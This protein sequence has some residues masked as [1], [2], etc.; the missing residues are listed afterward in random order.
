MT[1]PLP[2]TYIRDDGKQVIIWTY[3][4]NSW[5]VPSG[6]TSVEYLIVA[7][8]GGGG[9]ALGTFG[10][11]IIQG[12]CGAGGAGGTAGAGG[13]TGWIYGHNGN[14][15][16]FGSLI[17]TGGGGG[18]FYA[19]Y[20]NSGIGT[21]YITSHDGVNGGSGGGAGAANSTPG[22]GISSQGY[23]GGAGT[24]K[25][26]VGQCA[27]GGGGAGGSG[28]A[29]SITGEGYCTCITGAGG[30]AIASDITGTTEYYGGG[31]SGGTTVWSASHYAL[32]GT[33]GINGGAGGSVGIY[34]AVNGNAGSHGFGGGGGGGTSIVST[35]NGANGGNGG[36]GCVIIAYTPPPMAPV[37]SFS[38]T[39]ISGHPP[40]TV[41]FTDTS[42][43]TPTSWLWNF[44]DETTSTLQN[45]THIYDEIGIYTI[46]LTAT[47]AIGL[48]STSYD[49]NVH[50]PAPPVA[51][52]TTNITTGGTPLT[53]IFTDTSINTPTSWL[54]NFGDGVTSTSQ[55]PRHT[56]QIS[57][58]LPVQY[59]ATLTVTNIDGSS[60]KSSTITVTV[61][62]LPIANFTTNVTSGSAPLTVNF[63]DTSTKS[64]TSWTWYFGDGFMSTDQNPTHVYTV[65]KSYIVT[66]TAL[67]SAG[68]SNKASTITV[69]PVTPPPTP[70]NPTT[71]TL[72]ELDG[73]PTLTTARY[74]NASVICGKFIYTCGGVP[75]TDSIE[76]FEINPTTG[77]LTRL[78][79]MP[80]LLAPKRKFAI[81]SVGEYIYI[82]GGCGTDFNTATK[83]IEG[84]HVNQ[85]T[86]ALTR[87]TGMPTLSRA[88]CYHGASVFSDKIL[89]LGG[90]FKVEY[91]T[92]M[93]GNVY[94]KD[95]QDYQRDSNGEYIEGRRGWI[96][97]EFGQQSP[98]F[99]YSVNLTT[100]AL[101]LYQDIDH[102]YEEYTGDIR[103]QCDMAIAPYAVYIKTASI[104]T[105]GGVYYYYVFY[106]GGTDAQ[107]IWWYP[108]IKLAG[109]NL[110]YDA[111]WEDWLKDLTQYYQPNITT[112][113]ANSAVI[114]QS[115]L[116]FIGGLYKTS[117]TTESPTN[118]IC[119][120]KVNDR[121]LFIPGTDT[122]ATA[123]LPQ[124][125]MYWPTPIAETLAV[126]YDKF[127]Y[128][129]G[130]KLSNDTGGST[131]I[132]GVEF[133]S[134]L[135]A[136]FTV[137]NSVNGI[138]ERGCP[139]SVHFTD[140]S[141]GYATSY[142]WD[143]GDGTTSTQQNITHPYTTPGYYTV[144]LTISNG[145][146]SST[147]T[148][149]NGTQ[150]NYCV[151]IKES[152]TNIIS[153]A[154]DVVSGMVPLTVHFSAN[155]DF[156]AISYLW[157]FG[158]THTSTEENPT[159]TY[160][161]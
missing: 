64:P 140:T 13:S 127:I 101:S 12:G 32:I 103:Q 126:S 36:A 133:T 19:T 89:C 41:N 75:L 129:L 137:T 57:G 107:R 58:I 82:I 142:L 46:I 73:M 151:H 67:N 76:G 105:G 117:S 97:L 55:N 71:L 70:V 120:Y 153:I 92:N 40:L 26:N 25:A 4:N 27:G 161:E 6:V 116:F 50:Q 102:F 81:A 10:N 118:S 155:L 47:N 44:G 88:V 23:S 54:W 79:G 14:D 94:C 74:Q 141:V 3:Q 96:K 139:S 59:T 158:D 90:V 83:V 60:S 33:P 110:N 145:D 149:G 122:H 30:L 91:A 160:T 84:F 135:Q 45:P 16:Q 112:V 20:Q 148:I 147:Y 18:G 121:S 95:L 108:Q 125:L 157:D 63:T 154:Q 78:T 49:I 143:F 53:V 38:L 65:A 111:R 93:Y 123:K 61:S 156:D 1:I 17:A 98:A 15:S 5:T 8:G 56:Y 109:H 150:T 42:T 43:N 152:L 31:G 114:C 119:V 159:H 130:G 106:A 115:H 29:A 66:L 28:G 62:T 68:G 104:S 22:S 7:G 138:I 39:P 113:R 35:K 52:F 99:S 2:V 51:N 124:Y 9:A 132:T 37:A 24:I 136:H 21:Y 146:L 72:T 134:N 69:R 100:G 77:A 87:L 85:T 34:S 48:H 128:T 144:S 131:L 80:T 86:G 11:D